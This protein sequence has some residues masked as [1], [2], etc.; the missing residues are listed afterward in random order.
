MQDLPDWLQE[1][2][3]NL[4]DESSPL[5][6]L[7]NPAPKDQDTSSSSHELPYGVASKSGTGLGQAQ[8]PHSLPERPKLR[9][10]LEDKN[11]E[12]LLAEDV[13]EQSCPKRKISVI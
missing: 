2:R 10:L 12:G 1:F 7:E 11:N 8:Y 13:L 6:P 9:Y 5:E 4:V 3:E